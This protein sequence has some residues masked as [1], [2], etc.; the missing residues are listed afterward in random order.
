MLSI[1]PIKQT[2]PLLHSVDGPL[3]KEMTQ[4]VATIKV[5]PLSDR[6]EDEYQHKTNHKDV[7]QVSFLQLKSHLSESEFHH[8]ANAIDKSCEY[9]EAVND[10]EKNQYR[11]EVSATDLDQISL[12]EHRRLAATIKTRDRSKTRYRKKESPY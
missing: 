1:N 8:P 10:S 5:E 4:S 6:R 11:P 7:P 2:E 12:S 9:A 3:P